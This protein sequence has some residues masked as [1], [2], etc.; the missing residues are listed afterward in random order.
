M[1]TRILLREFSS[2]IVRRRLTEGSPLSGVRVISDAITPTGTERGGFFE[3][4]TNFL[5]KGVSFVGW[6]G[7][8]LLGG[9]KITAVG[10]FRTVVDT[11]TFIYNFNWNITDE[12][13]D[14]KFANFKIIL[15]GHLG[16]VAGNAAG[17]LVC[18]VLPSAAMLTINEPLGYY[19]L[20]EVGE[21]ALD[22]FADN[23]ASFLRS[24]FR[25]SAQYFAYSAFKN[26]RKAIKTLAKDPNSTTSLLIKKVFGDRLFD[27]IGNWGEEGSKPWSFKLAEEERI[28]NIENPVTQEFVEEFVDEF[29]DACIEAGYIVAQGIDNWVFMQREQRR[30]DEENERLVEIVPNRENPDES[31]FVQ[32]NADEIRTQ[33]MSAIN[34]YNLVESRDIGD[35][36]GH[37]L[38][39]S[40]K[41]PH[42]DTFI[43]I[44]LRGAPRPPF[45]NADGTNAKRTQIEIPN[46]KRSQLN[47]KDIKQAVG[48]TNGYMWGRFLVVAR[49]EDDHKI[50]FYAASETEGKIVLDRL[51]KLTK[52]DLLTLTFFEETREGVRRKFDDLYK[53]P[54]RVYPS[55]VVIVN[56]Y[57]ILTQNEGRATTRGRKQQRKIKFP[58]YTDNKPAD[59]DETVDSLFISTEE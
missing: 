8:K 43:K 25:I 15:A 57:K 4:I 32:G 22:E 6:I 2:R 31:I 48:S 40:I 1:P 58:L 21:E 45:K 33:T 46:I 26:V 20:K 24:L 5:G 41:K 52:S 42:K 59:F 51:L 55:H 3:K 23:L 38:R 27:A 16:E 34:T 37:P 17:Y 30:L 49:L 7:G 29:K 10:I 36:V 53:E 56:Q 54:T 13:I 14:Q 18:G 11:L 35:W 47:W 9:L 39:E 12:Q 28:E 19:L 44:L 50:T